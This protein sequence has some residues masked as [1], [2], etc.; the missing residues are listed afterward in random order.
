MVELQQPVGADGRERG[1]LGR[2]E[3]AAVGTGHAACKLVGGVV[4][5]ER[6]QHV[7]RDGVVVLPS[8]GREIELGCAELVADV[9]AAVAGDAGQYCLLACYDLV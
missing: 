5:K 9:E 2:V 6:A 1:D 7:A 4:G 8:H 3:V